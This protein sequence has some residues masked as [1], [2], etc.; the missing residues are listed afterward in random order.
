MK[1][2]LAAYPKALQLLVISGAILALT[3]SIVSS[4]PAPPPN[5][6]GSAPLAGTQSLTLYFPAVFT[7]PSSSA[8]PIPSAPTGLNA[9]AGD[10]RVTLVWNANPEP[11]VR[12]Y[13]IYSAPTADG[14]FT[15]RG[16][17]DAA[18]RVYIQS[19][20]EDGV[21]Y[22]FRIAAV[23]GGSQVSPMSNSIQVMTAQGV[24]FSQDNPGHFHVLYLVGTKWASFLL[25]QM[26]TADA[27]GYY[28]QIVSGIYFNS[29]PIAASR[30]Y[31]GD[32]SGLMLLKFNTAS[33]AVPRLSGSVE[34]LSSAGVTIKYTNVEAAGGVDPGMLN[35]RLVVEP[36]KPY[37]QI[38]AE[39]TPSAYTL[40][41]YSWN[42]FPFYGGVFDRRLRVVIPY[43]QDSYYVINGQ[44]H[45]IRYFPRVK[46]WSLR[47]GAEG[48]P[49]SKITAG[50][51]FPSLSAARV[52][53]NPDWAM[54]NDYCPGQQDSVP[55]ELD[56]VFDQLF[57]NYQEDE[58]GF[59]E[60]DQFPY[61]W[62][63]ADNA[64][65]GVTA[66]QTSSTGINYWVG[67][68]NWSGAYGQNFNTQYQFAIDRLYSGL[69]TAAPSKPNT[70]QPL[71]EGRTGLKPQ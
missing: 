9:V 8:E 35:I 25:N 55:Y 36:G 27:R 45:G 69:A 1:F 58:G 65:V 5:S 46:P 7:V 2:H 12:S 40:A 48:T 31:P 33:T 64:I 61:A 71:Y 20:L 49:Y 62:Q 44:A 51:F 39:Q 28:E 53:N 22:Y 21:T 24:S 63:N 17:V 19:G 18:T 6:T 34:S 66:G 26:T 14:P 15:W 67:E 70:A 57:L 52:L 16:S 10:H 13:Y 38:R 42:V 59:C 4:E 23:T 37:L 11:S 47:M 30:A 41:H 54:G 32:L 60:P 56:H 3:T 29:I 50:F 68:D 43:D